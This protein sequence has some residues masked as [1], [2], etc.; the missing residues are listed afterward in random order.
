M[1]THSQ[2]PVAVDPESLKQAQSIWHNFVQLI[3]IGVIGNIILLIGMAIF[4]V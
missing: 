3:K 1:G 4:L 2:T